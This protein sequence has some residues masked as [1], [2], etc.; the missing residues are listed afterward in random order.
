ML[1]SVRVHWHGNWKN[2]VLQMLM[3]VFWVNR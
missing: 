3:E 2:Y 1:I